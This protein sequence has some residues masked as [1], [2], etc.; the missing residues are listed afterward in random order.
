MSTA[1]YQPVTAIPEQMDIPEHNKRYC[2]INGL[3][4]GT[5]K[6]IVLFLLVFH[7]CLETTSV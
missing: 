7:T 1:H 2:K 4:G 5:A 3:C 6:E